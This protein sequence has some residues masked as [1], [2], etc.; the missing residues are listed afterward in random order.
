[1]EEERGTHGAAKELK[2]RER[3]YARQLKIKRDAKM[4]FETIADDN[5]NFMV[6]DFEAYERDQKV[7]TEAG[8][9]TRIGGQWQSSHIRIAN[10]SHLRN[11]KYVPD[12]VD[13]FRF[14]QSVFLTKAVLREKLSGMLQIPN[15]ILVAH[16]FTN[17]L[18][19]LRL[20]GITIPPEVRMLD[21]Q[22]V[23][24]YFKASKP[25]SNLSDVYVSLRAML[26]VLNIHPFCLHN[27]GNDS[28]YTSD[29]LQL[30]VA[31]F[32]NSMFEDM[33]LEI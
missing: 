17:E 20:L 29:A 33:A 26:K 18:K 9:T 16:G 21:T 28:K 3:L 13:N 15:L 25:S 23:F 4:A 8:I 5:W 22:N 31:A 11:G 6:V 14:G 32:D 7:I 1:M 2:Q 10:Y 30:M 19:Y 27:A 24:S 12:E